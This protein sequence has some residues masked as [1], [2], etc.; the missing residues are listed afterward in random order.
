LCTADLRQLAAAHAA[1]G[2]QLIVNRAG[3]VSPK[4][5]V[6]RMP[7]VVETEVGAASRFGAIQE[8]TM[9]DLVHT[10]PG[11]LDEIII[12]NSPAET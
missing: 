1:F 4:T 7:E 6:E 3:L 2:Q 12:G 8:W 5:M 10:T 9:F 11:S